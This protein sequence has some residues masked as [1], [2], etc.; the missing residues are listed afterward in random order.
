MDYS[1]GGTSFDDAANSELKKGV[2]TEAMTEVM[3]DVMFPPFPQDVCADV[4]V[5]LGAGIISLPVLL[6]GIELLKKKQ[7][8]HLIISGGAVINDLPE[9]KQFIGLLKGTGLPLPKDGEKEADYM[10]RFLKAAGIPEENY[11]IE[12]TS[13]NTGEN[14]RNIAKLDVFQKAESVNLIGLLPTRA[15][16]TMRKEEAG[17]PAKI[18]TLT[19]VVPLQG[20]TRDNWAD[21]PIS[22]AFVMREFAKINPTNSN[23]YIAQGYCKDVDLREE[24]W[25]ANTFLKHLTA[26]SPPNKREPSPL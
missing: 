22:R 18:A 4:G 15:L 23:N 19:N 2:L 3:T 7:I 6:Q 5:V 8:G 20:I 25:R 1:I 14:F 24:I 16:M 17:L 11:T 21:N 13:E 26:A 12:N 10:A 9:T